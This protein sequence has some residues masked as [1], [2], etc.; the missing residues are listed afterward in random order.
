MVRITIGVIYYMFL[1]LFMLKLS[2][3]S[4]RAYF[5]FTKLTNNNVLGK[6]AICDINNWA[7]Q[8]LL[9]V[10]LAKTQYKRDNKEPHFCIKP[11]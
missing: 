1:F 9:L 8:E 11:G 5:I 7:I 6:L 10:D 2:P 3:S 4:S